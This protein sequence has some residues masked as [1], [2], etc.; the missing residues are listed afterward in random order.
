M[1]CAE[2]WAELW[3]GEKKIEHEHTLSSV[4]VTLGF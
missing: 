2:E 4:V 3:R 1:L